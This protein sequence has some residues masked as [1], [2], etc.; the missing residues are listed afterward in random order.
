MLPGSA[1]RILIM[2]E[3]QA[4]HRQ[5]ME[6]TQI[7]AESR[8]GLLGVWFAFLLGVGCMIVAVITIIFVP[9]T[10]GAICGTIFGTTGIASI[11]ASFLKGTRKQ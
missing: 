10:A 2:A 1:D 8:D 4:A 5:K 3:K 9:N 7:Q 6:A 11:I